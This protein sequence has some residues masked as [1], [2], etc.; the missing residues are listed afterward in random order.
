MKNPQDHTDILQPN[1]A[2]LFGAE[3]A[4][5]IVRPI[6]TGVP[7]WD[8]ACDETG[9]LGLGDWWY[10]VLG[11]ASN[12]GKTNMALHMLREA[13]LGGHQPSL[14]SLETPRKGIQRK[15]YSQLTSFGFYDLLP[16]RFSKDW[17]TKSARLKAEIHEFR[18]REPVFGASMYVIEHPNKPNL[19]AIMQDVDNLRK[20]GSRLIVLDH[21]QLVKAG[22]QEIAAAATEV[23]E[24]LRE[25]AHSN[26]V[27]IIGLSQLNRGAST[28]RDRRPTMHDLWGGTSMESNA[29]QVMLIDHSRQD[30]A[31][32]R[33]PHL[34]RTYLY[35]DKNREGPARI[36]IPVEV[37]F[38]TGV[39][40]QA[41]E[42]EVDSWPE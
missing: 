3:L 21:L 37:D 35:L 8:A 20:E 15:L 31:D 1:T 32:K 40:R 25:Y 26:G 23:S 38:K 39:W 18:Q 9:G 17:E 29:N 5:T 13:A 34:L 19:R 16:D 11:G 41:E 7:L 28:Q 14:I 12:S 36:A 30:Q 6:S 33:Y 10:V 27:C 24:A 2:F 22:Q 4:S 42:H